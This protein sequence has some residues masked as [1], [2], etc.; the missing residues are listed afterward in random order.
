MIKTVLFV[1]AGAAAA[2]SLSSTAMA[3]PAYLDNFADHYE[4]NGIDVGPL[5]DQES[6]GACHVRAGGGGARNAYGKDFERITLGEGEGFP[7]IEF[8]DSDKDGFL[9]LEEIFAL[10]APGKADAKPA[11]RVELA[12][13]GS[14]L[15]VTPASRCE[16]VELQAFGFKFGDK[17][18]ASLTDVSGA[19]TLKVDGTA[20]AILARCAKEG[21]AG[22]L[23]K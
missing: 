19:T 3:F 14:E 8:L 16:K 6:C 10:T 18:V 7:G 23:K 13:A 12:L 11:G 15:T 17:A 21:F 22:S 2:L 9:N 20:G 4:T 5:V 1:S